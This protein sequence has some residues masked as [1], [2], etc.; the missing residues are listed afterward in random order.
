MIEPELSLP[1]RLPPGTAQASRARPRKAQR[2][3]GGATRGAAR[4]L[5]LVRLTQKNGQTLWFRE[6]FLQNPYFEEYW[7]KISKS[8]FPIAIQSGKMVV[9]L[10]KMGMNQ[11]KLGVDSAEMHVTSTKQNNGCAA[12]AWS[13]M[14]IQA[15]TKVTKRCWCWFQAISNSISPLGGSCQLG[16]KI[17][18]KSL[19][20][21]VNK[22]PPVSAHNFAARCLPYSPWRTLPLAVICTWRIIQSWNRRG[23]V[24]FVTLRIRKFLSFMGWMGY[25]MVHPS[26]TPGKLLF[27]KSSMD[28][29][30]AIYD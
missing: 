5:Y 13:A 22:V 2:T 27:S 8:F 6:W 15:L 29:T 25:I 11:P 7:S 21:S 18:H 14:G 4:L 23:V 10:C 3:V 28:D 1:S 19:E 30:P 16:V 24:R 20:P 9:L 12:N 26:K 17:D